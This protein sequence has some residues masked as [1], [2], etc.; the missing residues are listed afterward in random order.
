MLRAE[1]VRAEFYEFRRQGFITICGV[2]LCTAGGGIHPPPHTVGGKF[3]HAYLDGE[4]EVGGLRGKGT[5]LGLFSKHI[6][7]HTYTHTKRRHTHRTVLYVDK[8]SITAT[9]TF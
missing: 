1:R 6:D 5:L 7:T 3:S 9:Q 2:G 4:R 8:Y